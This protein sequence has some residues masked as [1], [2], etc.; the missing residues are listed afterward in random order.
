MTGFIDGTSSDVNTANEQAIND[1]AQ[2][3]RKAAKVKRI[4]LAKRIWFMVPVID[5]TNLSGTLHKCLELNS[6]N[7][8]E[9]L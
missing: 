1:N 8:Q 9:L 4:T 2:V 7:I 3:Q 6:L 5:N